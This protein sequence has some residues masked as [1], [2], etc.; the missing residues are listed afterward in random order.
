MNKSAGCRPTAAYLPLPRLR[1]ISLLT[2][3]IYILILGCY[4]LIP[5]SKIKKHPNLQP[6]SVIFWANKYTKQILNTV[7]YFYNCTKS[8]TK[9]WLNLK[10]TDCSG[11]LFEIHIWGY[12]LQITSI[13]QPAKNAKSSHKSTIQRV[14]MKEYIIFTIDIK[15]K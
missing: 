10:L 3:Q 15:H 12:M 2:I 1:Q 9:E 5:F 13:T 4:M 8:K 7:S 14:D 11:Q 6:T